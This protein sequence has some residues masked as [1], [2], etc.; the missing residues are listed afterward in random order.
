MSFSLLS[1]LWL[2]EPDAETIARAARE[3]GLPDAEPVDL[4]SAYTEVFLL[5]VYPYGTAFTDFFGELNG[6]EAQRVAALYAAHGYGPPELTS[7]GAP[8]HLGL[9]LGFLAHLNERR[10]EIGDFPLDWA[11]VC[12]LAVEREPS[13]HRF[14]RA[15][16]KLTRETLLSQYVIHNTQHETQESAIS[17]QQPDEEL[18]LRDIVRFFLAPAQCGIFLSRSQLGQMA[19]ELGTRLPFGSRFEVAELLLASAGGEAAQIGQRLN[20]LEAEVEAWAAEYRTWA[21]QYPAWRTSAEGWLTRT[22][23][24]IRRLTEMR[25]M[26]AAAP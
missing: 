17:L 11:P 15:L 12:C 8:D 20:V 9:G 21:E 18:S 7:V 10:L 19:K 2:H 22:T 3:L 26:V 4:A 13:A 16:A 23:A 14:Y 5:N 6:P 24:A 1:H 25:L